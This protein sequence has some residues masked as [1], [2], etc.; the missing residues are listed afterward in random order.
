MEEVDGIFLWTLV[1]MRYWINSLCFNIFNFS[2]FCSGQQNIRCYLS[3]LREVD[4]ACLKSIYICIWCFSLIL[5][6]CLVAVEA[7]RECVFLPAA[8]W[9]YHTSCTPLSDG[10]STCGWLSVSWHSNER[11]NLA[12]QRSHPAYP[13]LWVGL[14][15]TCSK[16]FAEGLSVHLSL[17]LVQKAQQPTQAAWQFPAHPYVE[18]LRMKRALADWVN[19]STRSMSSSSLCRVLLLTRRMG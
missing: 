11:H 14:Q 8:G 4:P 3:N 17:G 9:Q 19:S 10:F 1:S 18:R 16:S 6:R 5:P 15:N 7:V 2:G 12:A 13:P